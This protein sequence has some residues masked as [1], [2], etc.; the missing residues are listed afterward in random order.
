MSTKQFERRVYSPGATRSE[1]LG[2]VLGVEP[3]ADPSRQ[4]TSDLEDIR[5]SEVQADESE[6]S[7]RLY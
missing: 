6:G 3:R 1:S 4:L 7:I 2:E 5:Q